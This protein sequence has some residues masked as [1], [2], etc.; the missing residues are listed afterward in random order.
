MRKLLAILF[1]ACL[2]F[3]TNAFA[4]KTFKPKFD[5]KTCKQS[6]LVVDDG[7]TITCKGE[8]IRVLGV[9]TPEIAHPKHGMNIDQEMGPEAKEFTENAVRNAKRVTFVRTG[10]DVYGRTL[11][12]V[13]LDGELLPVKLVKAGLG[14]ETVSR[15]GD[16]GM[17]EFAFAVIEAAK[18]SPKPKFQDPHDWRKKNQKR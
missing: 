9:D 12:Y 8:D 13:L 2:Y 18:V 11:A 14:Y 7:D 17:P 6:Q 16:N 5:F 4:G 15:Y 10:K 1:I 3:S